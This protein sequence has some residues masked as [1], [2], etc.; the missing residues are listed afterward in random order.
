M[1]PSEGH[2]QA[3]PPNELGS[4]APQTRIL[5]TAGPTHEPIDAVR[6]IGNRSSGR[7]GIAIAEAAHAKG[8]ATTLLL[9]PVSQQP[10]NKLTTLHFQTGTE[11]QSL[12]TE[13]WPTHDILFMAAA[14]CDFK[15]ESPGTGKWSRSEGPT[16]LK[17][18]PTPDI[19]AA[20]AASSAPH[21]TLIGFAL[22]HVSNLQARGEMK[23]REKG[24][25]AIV[26]N[27][28][29]TMDSEQVEAMLLMREQSPVRPE[30]ALSKSDFAA[31][32]IEQALC[33][34]GSRNTTT[35]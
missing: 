3:E 16:T 14:V 4:M 6:F 10:P 13:Q 8:C 34:H 35:S 17:L 9:G 23:L 30:G 20:T 15:P 29:E 21:Q 32:L 19:L 24:V 25:H 11:L 18:T 5:I 2:T 27:P 7:M 12:L 26:A 31:W 33:L 1:P 22:E 28:L